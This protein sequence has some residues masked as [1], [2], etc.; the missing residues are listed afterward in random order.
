MPLAVLKTY[1][2]EAITTRI[3]AHT[4]VLFVRTAVH[5]QGVESQHL[6]LK[7]ARLFATGNNMICDKMQCECIPP[8]EPV[9]PRIQHFEAF[10][11]LA[12]GYLLGALMMWLTMS[13]V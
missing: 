10:F 5:G 9:E 13:A 3:Q 7:L 12:G 1:R 4:S 8:P 2:L 11:L 6:L